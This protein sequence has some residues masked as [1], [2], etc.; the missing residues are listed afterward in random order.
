[1]TSASP[2]S[3]IPDM[4]LEGS[5]FFPAVIIALLL[6]GSFVLFPD[7]S[8]DITAALR[9]GI[10]KNFGWL[11]MG[12]GLAALGFALW[13]AFGRFAH[14]RLGAE[15]EPPEFSTPHWVAMMFTAGIGAGLATWAF[16]EPI[17]YLAT[18]PLGIE[19]HSPL[20]FEFAHMYPLLHWGL[21]P[22]AIYAVPAVPIAYMLYV[23]RKPFLRISESCDGVLPET[24]RQTIKRAMDVFIILGLLGGTAT[25]LG[26][27]VPLVSAAVAELFGVADTSLVK[28]MVLGLWV[29][30]FGSSTLRGLKKGIQV[31]ADIN[32]VMAGLFISFILF[33]GPTLFILDLTVNSFGLMLDNFFRA[34]LW[35]DPVS[36][37]SFPEDWTVFY[38]AWWIAFAVLVGLFVGRISRGRTVRQLI[39]GTLLWGSLGTWIFLAI[40]GGYSLHLELNNILPLSEILKEEGM[41]SLTA[42]IIGTL[43]YSKVLLAMFILL[44]LIFYATTM[45]S[46]AFVLAGICARNIRADQEPALYLRV[47]WITMIGLM[48]AGMIMSGNQ[49]TIQALTII[50]SLP[51]IPIMILMCVSIVRWL[52]QDQTAS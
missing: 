30:M 43:P 8:S 26:L 49:N 13:L 16:A 24:G 51:L 41:F 18:P 27:G 15:G 36:G 45:D 17:Y 37:G 42:Q 50:S 39:L 11:Y 3:S 9:I 25:S 1:M 23:K 4:R 38:W 32:M 29:V 22:W 33:V 10:T 40:A 7:A 20:A 52:Q 31:L 34:S 44:C 21:V 46:A 2:S 6:G 28:F 35:S 5:V 47:A 14:V 12:L 48:T 19:P